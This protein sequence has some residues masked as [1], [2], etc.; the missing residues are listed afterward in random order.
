[1]ITLEEKLKQFS[2]MIDEKVEQEISEELAEKQAE[3]QAFLEEEK[4]RIESALE[5]EKRSAL[6][7]VDRQ[8]LERISTIKQEEKRN[9]LRKNELFIQ[10]LIQKVEEK[11]RDFVLT[12]D[13]PPFIA[14]VLGQTLAKNEIA[15]DRQ[16]TIYICPSNFDEVKRQFQELLTERGYKHVQFKEGEIREIGGF[17]LEVLEDDIRFN[18]TIIRTMDNMREPIGQYLSNYVREG[19]ELNG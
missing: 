10:D 4:S 13:Y 19:T 11:S 12:P 8:K 18:K 9:Y 1:M 2:D 15:L 17:I 5:R 7:R 16:V 3:V 14:R 6:R